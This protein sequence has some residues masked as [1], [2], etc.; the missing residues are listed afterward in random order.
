MT[1]YTELNLDI[2][3][4]M[5]ERFT[6]QEL[7]NVSA[8][9]KTHRFDAKFEVERRIKRQLLH[10]G[11]DHS[12]LFAGMKEHGAIISGSV[13]LA[14]L[15][16]DDESFFGNDI[17][18]YL[19]LDRSASFTSEILANTDYKVVKSVP[20][21][22]SAGVVEKGHE[23]SSIEVEGCQIY[24]CS[25][26]RR[27]QWLKNPSGRS[28]N[29]IETTQD[30]PFKVLNTFYMTLVMNAVT[31]TGVVCL[32]P[33]LTMAKVGVIKHA[34][35]YQWDRVSTNVAKYAQRGFNIRDSWNHPEVQSAIGAHI[36]GKAR[37]CPWTLR[38]TR[39]EDCL[40]WMSYNDYPGISPRDSI[41]A[42]KWN[43]H[44]VY[45]DYEG[46]CAFAIA[47]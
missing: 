13:A 6:L 19:P 18:F 32:Y 36:C 4:A 16:P 17:D 9:D 14:A 38:D 10:F 47:E 7:V 33:E 45:D 23:H 1:D 41:P 28:I 44:P 40:L 46:T 24:P 30:H 25:F 34:Q 42:V 39:S 20:G 5:K 22:P 21:L 31:P 35:V 2:Q 8:L 11:L 29:I 27:I 43:H 37:C 26:A 3:R 12:V 15:F